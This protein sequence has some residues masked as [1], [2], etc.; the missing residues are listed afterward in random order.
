MTALKSSNVLQALARARKRRVPGTAAGL[1]LAQSI[2]Q[3]A[4]A[5]AKKRDKRQAQRPV[6]VRGP[7]YFDGDL[8]LGF[9]HEEVP[10]T[11]LYSP[12]DSQGVHVRCA[13]GQCGRALDLH[14][15]W[16]EILVLLVPS[17]FTGD[18]PTGW[19][20]SEETRRVEFWQ[21][22]PFCAHYDTDHQVWWGFTLAEGRTFVKNAVANGFLPKTAQVLVEKVLRAERQRQAESR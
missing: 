9:L 7:G 15:A 19:Q 20:L 14:V 10:T 2:V 16:D 21:P 12:Q 11:P 8:S 17:A 5:R 1:R 18:L 13:C 3:A 6:R 22:C 4:G